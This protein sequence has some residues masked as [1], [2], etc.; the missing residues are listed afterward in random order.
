MSRSSKQKLSTSSSQDR[1][2][3]IDSQL[4]KINE[5]SLFDTVV[6]T[7]FVANP[8]EYLDANVRIGKSQVGSS[9]SNNSLKSQFSKV[10]GSPSTR[11]SAMTYRQYLTYGPNKVIDASLVEIMPRNSIIGINITRGKNKNNLDR[12]EVFFP[13]FSHMSLPVKAGEQVWVFYDNLAGRKIG[14]WI[15]RKVGSIFVDDLN[16]THIDRHAIIAASLTQNV[17]ANTKIRKEKVNT[18]GMTFPNPA[19]D[20]AANKTLQVKEYD[21]I[22]GKSF[23]HGPE[24][25]EFVGEPVPRHSKKCSDLT[26]QGSNNTIITM[27]H[28]NDK[29]TGTV[30]IAV[31][32]KTIPG[33]LPNIRTDSSLEHDEIDKLSVLRGETPD[34][35]EGDIDGTE[36]AS[37]IITELDGGSIRLGNA[38]GAYIELKSNGDIC[39]VPANEGVV[40]LGGEDANKAMVSNFGSNTAGSVIGTP[41][42]TSMGGAVGAP[43]FGEFASKILVK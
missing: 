5:K 2:D 40:K 34:L 33:T 14:Y 37:L 25:L 15:S 39:I 26:L 1:D 16:Y 11:Q 43:G 21:N 8:E 10:S 9:N 42:A 27:T 17:N 31:G 7:D 28:E 6:V 41:F 24:R 29:N 20:N 35:T 12:E 32:R 36:S 19:L 23:S 22:L 18:F 3:F 13:F 4:S 38:S 30:K